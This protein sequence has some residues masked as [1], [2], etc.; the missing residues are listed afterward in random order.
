MDFTQGRVLPIPDHVI[1]HL[2]GL[3]DDDQQWGGLDY[4]PN[5]FPDDVVMLNA[6]Q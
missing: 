6:P 4:A 2:N 3:A 1:E 5:D